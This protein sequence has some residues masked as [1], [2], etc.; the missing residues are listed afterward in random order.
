MFF[1]SQIGLSPHRYFS[2]ISNFFLGFSWILNNIERYFIFTVLQFGLKS[3]AYIF[4]RLLRPLVEYWRRQSI[5]GV[6]YLDDG[7]G[8]AE[9]KELCYK[10]AQVV[11]NDIA[12]LGLVP[13]KDN[14]SIWKPGQT[15]E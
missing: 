11:K 7:F 5:N 2:R 4:T 6:L 9:N 14:K 13:N 12:R 1:L 15:I 10:H 8:L 3:I